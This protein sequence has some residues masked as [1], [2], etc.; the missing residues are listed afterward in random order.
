MPRKDKDDIEASSTNKISEKETDG[1]GK[2]NQTGKTKVGDEE[3]V[4]RCVPVFRALRVGG[5][6]TFLAAVVLTFAWV[7]RMAARNSSQSCG[8]D[9]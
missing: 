4:P 7:M 2:E 9:M 5:V 6:L 3:V 1:L 8:W